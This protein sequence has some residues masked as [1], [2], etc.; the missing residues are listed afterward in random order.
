MGFQ[1]MLEIHIPDGLDRFFFRININK[2]I[3]SNDDGITYNIV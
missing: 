2:V 1:W 3:S